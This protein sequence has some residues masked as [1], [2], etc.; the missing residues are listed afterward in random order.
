MAEAPRT[1]KMGE[2]TVTLLTAGRYTLGEVVVD[3][4]LTVLFR[5]D[6]DDSIGPTKE[7]T[8]CLLCKIQ[9]IRSCADEV[10]PPIKQADPNASC[11]D[12][13]GDCALQ[14]CTDKCT[15]VGGSGGGIIVIA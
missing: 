1:R 4:E 13:I 9:N 6:N 12:A 2:Y 14:R 8:E 5:A 11:S 15:S 10:C 3:D 7:E